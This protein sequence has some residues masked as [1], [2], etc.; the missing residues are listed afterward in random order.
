MLYLFLKEKF[1]LCCIVILSYYNIIY[2]NVNVYI[3]DYEAKSGL[4]NLALKP[5]FR[6]TV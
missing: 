6:I 2:K 1:P 4:Y 5:T 3:Y